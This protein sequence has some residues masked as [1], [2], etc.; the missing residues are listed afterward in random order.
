M[1]AATITPTAVGAA[2]TRALS[3]VAIRKTPAP[4]NASPAPTSTNAAPRPNKAGIAGVI[5]SPAIP[6]TVRTAARLANPLTIAPH[7]SPPRAIRAGVRRA[8][9]A[10]AIASAA[11]PASVPD[12]AYKAT[13]K[14][15]KDPARVARPFAICSIDI[16]P[17][18][19]TAEAI[20]PKA[21]ETNRSPAAVPIIFGIRRMAP[22]ITTRAPPIPAIPLAID[23]QFIPPNCAR[24]RESR[25]RQ[26]PFVTAFTLAGR[27]CLDILVAA[28]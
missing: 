21:R 8:S 14:I 7:D 25:F 6:I 23:P 19:I 13:A 3:P 2:T 24:V 22:A 1:K 11:A 18:L 15:V 10:A 9:P 4:A 17:I 28:L 20:L 16:P 27:Q 5:R 12:I 26:I